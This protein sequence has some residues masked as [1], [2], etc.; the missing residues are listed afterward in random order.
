MLLRICD[1]S[2]EVVLSLVDVT[3]SLASVDGMLRGSE[4]PSSIAFQCVLL[5][6]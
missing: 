2:A 6:C 5:T 3:L 1:T 4:A